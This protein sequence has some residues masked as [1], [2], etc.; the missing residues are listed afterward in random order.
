VQSH[1]HKLK[2]PRVEVK[3]KQLHLIDVT[4][5]M[6]FSSEVVDAAGLSAWSDDENP[7]DVPGRTDAIVQTTEFIAWLNEPD[8]DDFE[9]D[10]DDEGF[11]GVGRRTA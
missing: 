1:C 3:D 7:L 9:E 2:F 8:A 4:F 6:L 5:R 10:E 11:D